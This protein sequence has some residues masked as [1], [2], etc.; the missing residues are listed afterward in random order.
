MIEGD[1]RRRA[2][3]LQRAR[4]NAAMELL[5]EILSG[6]VGSRDEARRRLEEIYRS[7]ALQPIRGRAWPPD[8][9]DKE[10]ATVYIVGK[11]ALMLNEEEP[12]VFSKIFGYEESLEDIINTIRSSSND[13]E[14]RRFILFM[15]GGSVD[16]NTV[17]RILRIATTKYLLGFADENEVVQ[18]IRRLH[19]ILPE[20][21]NTVRKYARYFIAV[22]IAQAI[23]LGSVRSRIEK[24]AL[25]QALAAR[26]GLEKV[27]PDDEYVEFIAS[28]V[29]NVPKKVTQRVLGGRHGKQYERKGR[30]RGRGGSAAGS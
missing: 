17:A 15:L 16:D 19:E 14:A 10:L 9:W 5:S 21:S 11:Y 20:Q 24:E 6:R 27:M 4:I 25:K 7:K 8:I 12:D 18:L 2:R 26:I 13:D 29:F 1:E 3:E 28:N 30:S 22:R 23:A